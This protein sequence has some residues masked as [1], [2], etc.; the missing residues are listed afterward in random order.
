[1]QAVLQA[2]CIATSKSLPRA[3]LLYTSGMMLQTILGTAQVWPGCVTGKCD[4]EV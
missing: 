1:M 2:V 3:Q 4:Q